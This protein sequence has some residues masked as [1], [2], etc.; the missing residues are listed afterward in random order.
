MSSHPFSNGGSDPAAS[1]PGREVLSLWPLLSTL[2]RGRWII[3]AT[4]AASLFF[5]FRYVQT[6][7]TVWEVSSRLY[8]ENPHSGML[9]AEGLLVPSD[10]RNYVNTQAELLLSTSVLKG[11]LTRPE[12]AS[13]PLFREVHNKL[14]WLKRQLHVTVG[15]KDDIVSVSLESPHVADACTVVNATVDA[16]R[17]F[18]AS[19]K[20]TTVKELLEH[21]S[22]R[23]EEHET[24]FD[25]RLENLTDFLRQNGTLGLDR[26]SGGNY[27]LTALSGLSSALRQARAEERS[28]REEW[29]LA[30]NL[31]GTPDVLREVLDIQEG[32]RATSSRSR[33]A[34]TANL[35]RQRGELTNEIRDLEARR[36][37][38]LGDRT[39]A[40]PTIL[41]LDE[42]LEILRAQGERLDGEIEEADARL[43]AI[44]GEE[45]DAFV[46]EYLAA[47]K[48]QWEL[49]EG[50]VADFTE[51]VEAQR[52]I[53][54]ELGGKHAEYRLL[55]TRVE[56]Q[57]TIIDD[58]SKSINQLNLANISE[59]E[60]SALSIEVLDPA[61]V[62]TAT[63]AVSR[64][65]TLA[66]FACLGLVLGYALSWL[67]GALDHRLRSETDVT[68][69][70]GM[71]LLTVTPR[72]RLHPEEQDAIEQWE[73]NA[74]LSEAIR[75]LRT[76]VYFGMPEGAG[77][78]IHVTSPAKS[79]GKSTISSQLGIAMA[80]AGQKTLLIDADLRSPTQHRLF[81]F[82]NDA[83]LGNALTGDTPIAELT[84][85]TRVENLHILPAGPV[86]PNPAEMLNSRAFEELLVE[87]GEHYDRILVD[88]PPVLAVADSRV[89][90]NKCDVT[91]L[92]L[93]AD[94]TTHKQAVAAGE[95]LASVGA[96]ILGVVLNAM[97]SGFGTRYGS[98]YGYGYGRENEG[99]G[100]GGDGSKPTRSV[101]SISGR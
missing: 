61:S 59:D 67:R 38:F 62:E 85:P 77:K 83:G 84:L 88:S 79:D 15:Q 17:E 19:R 92:V 36:M 22:K 8:I 41:A 99:K 70:L 101:R 100:S 37:R 95:Q 81:H 91:I 47:L 3:L 25:S 39:E 13:N 10:S 43:A 31:I 58:L 64:T 60:E 71:T 72:L 34:G 57:R 50:K 23:I 18:H 45:E 96:K 86:P 16:Y 27:E 20:K 30:Q 40:H 75:S 26:D 82:D 55:D 24:E 76:G 14:G 28:A 98:D 68:E 54:Q 9:T 2:W 63:V 97:P 7:G 6:R 4:T 48:Q 42:Q 21:L 52:R 56:Q 78:V 12:V 51:Q 93:R 11:A 74:S 69:E 5:G 35:V 32:R 94:K 46:R 1:D 90:A 29:E 87:L 89:V 49:A 80:Q 53:V 44:D 73:E 33:E 65:R 66:V